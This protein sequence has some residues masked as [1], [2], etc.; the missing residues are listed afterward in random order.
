MGKV[1]KYIRS[2]IKRI[3]P[4]GFFSPGGMLSVCMTGGRSEVFWGFEN[5]HSQTIHLNFFSAASEFRKKMLI[6]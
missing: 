1:K 5:L 4:D 2:Y 6:N 3:N